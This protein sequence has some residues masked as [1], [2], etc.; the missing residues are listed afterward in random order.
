MRRYIYIY[1]QSQS[2]N[3]VCALIWILLISLAQVTL[4]RTIPPFPLPPPFTMNS[5][6]SLAAAEH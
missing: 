1:L 4:A 2:C 3:E 6:P 5:T